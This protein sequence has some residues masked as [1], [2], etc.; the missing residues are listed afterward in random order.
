MSCHYSN[1]LATHS[2]HFFPCIRKNNQDLM[3]FLSFHW[4]HILCENCHH[5]SRIQME[6]HLL[7]TSEFFTR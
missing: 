6:N 1:T 7:P 5:S 2:N 3:Y 4:K